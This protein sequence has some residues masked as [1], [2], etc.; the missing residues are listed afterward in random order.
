MGVLLQGFYKKRPNNAVPSPADRLGS[1][2]HSFDQ[3]QRI[4][5]LTFQRGANQVTVT[6][7]DV[8]S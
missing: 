4:N 5:F 2:T 1:V 8:V 6:A 3:N 7:P